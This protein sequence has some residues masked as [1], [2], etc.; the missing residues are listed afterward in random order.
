[1]LAKKEPSGWMVPML[2]SPVEGCWMVIVDPLTLM[3]SVS[4]NPSTNPQ[5]PLPFEKT[6]GQQDWVV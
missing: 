6:A 5:S 1:M 3:M 4:V 2:T